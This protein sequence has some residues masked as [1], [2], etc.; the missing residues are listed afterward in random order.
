MA[1]IKHKIVRIFVLFNKVVVL[2]VIKCCINA[3]IM[4]ALRRNQFKPDNISIDSNYCMKHCLR[5]S[6][7]I[8]IPLTTDILVFTKVKN[9]KR[10][11][12][13]PNIISKGP[14]K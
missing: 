4:I 12:S 6:G 5:S 7:L 11:V 13:K 10:K 1:T 8:D 3:I 14:S 9:V 2:I